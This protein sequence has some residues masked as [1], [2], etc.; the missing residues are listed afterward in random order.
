VKSLLAKLL[1]LCFLFVSGCGS[2]SS[3]SLNNLSNNKSTAFWAWIAGDNSISQLGVYGVKGIPSPTNKP[4]A[5]SG[6]AS[7]TDHAGNFWLF[8]GEGS[9]FNDL[10]RWDG[11][12]WTWIHGP[13]S[14]DYSAPNYG[15]KGIPSP[16]NIPGQ[17]HDAV[18]WVDN[19]GN[20]WL[21]GGVGID[22]SGNGGY[23]ND[24]WRWD[25]T[26]WTWVSGDMS[27]GQ[28]GIYG[29]KGIASVTNK[30]G[31]RAGAVSWGDNT[32][33]LW[34]FGG[35]GY[36]INGA[37]SNLNDLWKW[38]GTNWTWV[39]GNNITSEHGRYGTKG[40]ASPSNV[41]GS[42]Q[43]AV[44]AVDRKGHFLLFGGSGEGKL[45]EGNSG[46]LNDLWKW[47]GTNWT[48][49]SGD[50]TPAYS[51][52]VYGKK[53]MPAPANKIGGRLQAVSWGDTSGNF[54]V[55]GGRGTDGTGTSGG[56]LNDLWKW[57]GS[58]WTWMA[59]DSSNGQFGSYGVKGS[60]SATNTPGARYG[61]SPW[62]DKSGGL[63]LFGG[64]GVDNNA[65]GYLNDLWCFR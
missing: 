5:R 14:T 10:W 40:V 57:D 6:A 35:L 52:P 49:I 17:R 48:W 54:W 9:G 38:D 65:L 42:R 27:V 36:D 13:T 15:T 53:G 50:D 16:S 43:Y 26:N 21:F 51:Y 22:N 20:L 18:S 7:W 32:G 60:K 23:L 64:Y 11:T 56:S 12:F 24:L 61:S 1:A 47:D 4:G 39:S 34:I 37:W 33:T 59:G 19:S 25:G 30:P 41:P 46:Y 58:A 31:G 28:A 29:S 55:F 63:W 3:S 2:N 45:G 62:I 8:G 44:S